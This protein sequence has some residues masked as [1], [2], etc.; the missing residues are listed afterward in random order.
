LTV[1]LYFCNHRNIKPD[2]LRV[3]RSADRF[4]ALGDCFLA[5]RLSGILGGAAFLLMAV[6]GTGIIGERLSG[7]W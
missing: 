5:R 3:T 7:Q 1:L 4:A 2:P 6:A